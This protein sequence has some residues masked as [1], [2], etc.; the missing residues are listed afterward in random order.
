MS[1]QDRDYARVTPRP[2]PFG[3]HRRT[4][5]F[6]GS[7][8]TTLIT[9]NVVIFLLGWLSRPLGVWFFEQGAL[10]GWAVLHGD[11]WRLITAQYLHIGTMHVLFNMI[12]LHFL[13]RPLERGWSPRK[14]FTIYTL[15]GISGNLFF[16]FLAWRGV[17]DIR[18]PAVGASGCVLGLLGIVAVRFP[19]AMLYFFPIPFPVR[20]RT[21][22]MIF[23]GIA[24]L[25]VVGRGHNFG[26]EACHLA[27][28]GFGV[29]WALKGE[30]WWARKQWRMP[31]IRMRQ[32]RPAGRSRFSEKIARR[33]E[34]EATIDRILKKV[35]EG[36]IHSL[37]EAERRA[38]Q[39]ATDRQKERE[40]QAGR[41]DRL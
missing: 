4:Q 32:N 20:I 39:E 6:G 5:L 2:S 29:W 19:S 41:V 23:A 15:C 33:D 30:A 35:Y 24:F 38:L 3:G 37:S 26:G 31:K 11:I 36:G 34:D 21:A 18:T 25:S 7:I 1:W 27:G 10:Q 8:V 28:L 12:G 16:V 9:V 13:G 40:R 17:I 22:A 14:F